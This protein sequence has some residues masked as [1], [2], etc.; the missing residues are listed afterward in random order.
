MLTHKPRRDAEHNHTHIL[1]VA[2]GAFA[3]E[4]LELSMRELARRADVG[5]ATLYRHFPSRQE[6]VA[7]VL[8]QHVEICTQEMNAALN[9]PDPWHALTAIMHGYAERQARDRRLHEALLGSHPVAVAFTDQR[10]AHVTALAHLLTRAQHAGTVRSDVTIQDVRIGLRAMTA[11]RA[12]PP[13][14]AAS[15]TRRL[16]NVLLAGI[17]APDRT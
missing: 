12:L 3:T 2:R 8:T 4:G 10:Q 9:D 1:S 6:L 17:A 5:A 15:M 7:A 14:R 13:D 11:F 16:T